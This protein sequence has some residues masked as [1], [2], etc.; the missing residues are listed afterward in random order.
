VLQ[1][2]RA[3]FALQRVVWICDR[4]MVSEA[5]LTAMA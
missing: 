2:V 4:G 5:A 3:R 1:D